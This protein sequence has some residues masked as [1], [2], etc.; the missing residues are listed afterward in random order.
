MTRA[1]CSLLE[2]HKERSPSRSKPTRVQQQGWQTANVVRFPEQRFSLPACGA[3]CF[4]PDI[5]SSPPWW[6]AARSLRSY[7]HGI[8]RQGAGSTLPRTRMP[9]LPS[10]SIDEQ[11]F[12]AKQQVPHREQ[13]Y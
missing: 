10:P 12:G 1:N 4:A 5:C 13:C 6:L 9:W 7:G 8:A 2:S 11:M 3:C